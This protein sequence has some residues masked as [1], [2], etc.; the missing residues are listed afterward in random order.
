MSLKKS[1]GKR[2]RSKKIKTPPFCN[3]ISAMQPSTGIYATAAVNRHLDNQLFIVAIGGPADG[4]KA[5]QLFFHA[6]R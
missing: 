3:T 6:E 1:R 4:L 5:F 2:I